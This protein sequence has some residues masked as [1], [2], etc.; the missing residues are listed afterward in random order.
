[1]THDP[2]KHERRSI[3]LPGYDYRLGG[4]YHTDDF[5]D[6]RGAVLNQDPMVAF[7]FGD[8]RSGYLWPRHSVKYQ[9][10][11]PLQDS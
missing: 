10:K 7:V 9:N 4:W 5:Y 11:P 3:R 6:V 2:R 8:S 1:M